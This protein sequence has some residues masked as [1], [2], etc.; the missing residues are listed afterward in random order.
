[1]RLVHATVRGAVMGESNPH[2]FLPRLLELYRQGRFPVDRIVQTY[3][4]SDIN[5]A[6]SDSES[7][8]AVKPVIL[9]PDRAQA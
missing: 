3:A 7:G 1:M 8:G 5:Q 4:F 2:L 9:F 6:I